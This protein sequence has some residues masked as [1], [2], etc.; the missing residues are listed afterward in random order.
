MSSSVRLPSRGALIVLVHRAV[1]Q[2]W[3]DEDGLDRVMG[4]SQIGQLD[5]AH[6]LLRELCGT[7]RLEALEREAALEGVRGEGVT[8]TLA[9][10]G[11]A[12]A[13]ASESPR[14]PAMPTVPSRPPPSMRDAESRVSRVTG[15][16]SVVLKREGDSDTMV[17]GL[18]LDALTEDERRMGRR[19]EIQR[20]KIERELGRGGV[21]LVFAA[22]DVEVGRVAALKIL[23][24]H[25]SKAPDLVRRFVTEARITAQLEHPGIVPVY[26]IGVLPS[27]EPFY[28]MRVI[29][30]HALSDVLRDPAVRGDW[31]LT[32][33][34]GVFAQVCMAI[35]YA[36]SRGVVHR[37]LKP[38]NILIG[39]YG[40]VYVTDWGIAQ[41]QASALREGR[42]SLG[43]DGATKAGSFLGTPGYMAPEQILDASSVDARS[44]VFAL[45]VIL[46]EVLTS[47]L[48][49]AAKTPVLAIGRTL[50]EEPKAPAAVNAKAP[51]VLSELCVR[52]L[53]KDAAER[54]VGCAEIVKEL[55]AY[56][57]GSKEREKQ[58]QVA[59]GLVVEA[60]KLRASADALGQEKR[61][62]QHEA[63]WELAGVEPYD[64]LGKKRGAWELEERAAQAEREAAEA[65]GEATV[66]LQQALA[67]DP[68]NAEAKRSLAE[69]Y[70]A[71]VLGAEETRRSGERVYFERMLRLHDDGS[72][73]LRLR[74][75]ARL[76][77]ESRPT[78]ARVVAYRYMP[79]G[80]TFRL[81]PPRELG[82][83][84]CERDLQAGSWLLVF[85]KEGY[86]DV[87][88]P[89]RLDRGESLRADI[90]FYTQA[91]IGEGFQYVPGGLTA[92]GGDPDAPHSL[93][94]RRV[95]LSDFAIGRVPVT[96]R[97][98]LAFLEDV[99]RTQPAL[100]ERRAPQ[101]EEALGRF[102]F[103]VGE[104]WVP[105]AGLLGGRRSLEHE[106]L[107]GENLERALRFPVCSVSWFDAMHYAA[108]RSDKEGQTLRLPTEMEWERAARGA[109]ARFFP[110]G[111]M[112]DPTF[113]K[114]RD[115][116]V[117]IARPEPVG[118]FE[119]DLSPF[120]VADLAGGVREWVG[121]VDGEMAPPPEEGDS[122]EVELAVRILRGG[123]WAASG[124]E[125]R[126]AS[127]LRASPGLRR[128]DFG[129]RLVRVLSP[130]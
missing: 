26:D 54:P 18:E 59:R 20:Y 93:D 117:G 79:S 76:V 12:I 121:D 100:A 84:P 67:R 37:D 4:L 107:S 49:F 129:F 124:P 16:G 25:A 1:R 104:R 90:A 7:T 10:T 101:M 30:R 128:S 71:R 95:A 41:V 130:R 106:A 96:F 17:G 35:G 72:F 39:D 88:L 69:I 91:E 47:E 111:D 89:V 127:R 8:P 75:R 36:H 64:E 114:M 109:D 122:G 94:A 65:T 24:E 126:A 97:E 43:A 21:G 92:I 44:D 60:Q 116:R 108:W 58:R 113:C 31:P 87:R 15:V 85:E 9:A 112:F 27:G 86:P 34:V 103:R 81:G 82:V 52:C 46:Y 33:L 74:E 3:L 66:L 11:R 55:E 19:P 13:R 42:E 99:G 51:M 62:L 125:C 6:G 48:P 102:A 45:G 56:L 50:R 118:Q 5:E 53:A 28:T 22:E 2:G 29:S 77:L 32:R 123:S 83:T 70:Y 14:V 110:W 120:S 40:E 115:A 78:G 61:T 80:H 73:A 57:E 105:T 68:E 98:Y 119:T 63:R 23:N 38:D